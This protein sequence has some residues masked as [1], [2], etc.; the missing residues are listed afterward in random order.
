MEL[1]VKG[2]KRTFRLVVGVGTQRTTEFLNVKR[3]QILF[4]FWR[5]K[6]KYHSAP[7]N[8][9]N[10]LRPINSFRPKLLHYLQ[11]IHWRIIM[12]TFKEIVCGSLIVITFAA[13]LYSVPL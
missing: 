4:Y 2:E 12:G 6:F 9:R 5:W 7:L 1:D 13:I 10:Q 8:P 3:L 11:H